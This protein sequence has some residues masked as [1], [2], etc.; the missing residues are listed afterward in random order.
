MSL[1]EHIQEMYEDL[2]FKREEVERSLESGVGDR[3]ILMKQLTAL[4]RALGEPVSED[5]LFDQWEKDLAEGKVP[6]LN[7]MPGG[8]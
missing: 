1:S 7:A 2:L 4:N 6:D 8:E 3:E 5:D